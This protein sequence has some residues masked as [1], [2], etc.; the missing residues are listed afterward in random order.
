[1]TDSDLQRAL[2]AIERAI[3]RAPT[4]P[5]LDDS[6]RE[7]VKRFQDA[8]WNR[9]GTDKSWVWR[10]WYLARNHYRNA[11]SIKK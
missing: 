5:I 7:A 11:K 6:L 9:P 2:E 10:C 1:M 8:P 3:E 4:G